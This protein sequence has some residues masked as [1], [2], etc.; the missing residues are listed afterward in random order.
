[1]RTE[2]SCS[3]LGL[4]LHL[5]NLH[6]FHLPRPKPTPPAPTPDTS[7]DNSTPSPADEFQ[8][9]LDECEIGDIGSDAVNQNWFEITTKT[10][11]EGRTFFFSKVVQ[12]GDYPECI[13]FTKVGSKLEPI[14]FYRSF[15][16]GNWKVSPWV[17][18]EGYSKGVEGHYGG[19]LYTQETR[20]SE[21]IT[22]V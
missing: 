13:A 8:T 1:M 14:L 10:V 21:E 4:S 22:R 12:N 19:G 20:P 11:L 3:S 6:Q 9:L 15:S 2:R 16:D 5:I 18:K 7:P 17:T